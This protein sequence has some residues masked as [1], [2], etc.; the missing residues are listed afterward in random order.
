MLLAVETVEKR[1]GKKTLEMTHYGQHHHLVA[2]YREE[3]EVGLRPS[4]DLDV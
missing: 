1:L 3:G 2:Y 4:Q